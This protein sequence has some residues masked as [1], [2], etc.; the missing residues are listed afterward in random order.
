M[1]VIYFFWKRRKLLNRSADIWTV[2]RNKLLYEEIE[3]I[4]NKNVL[5]ENQPKNEEKKKR[6]KII[7]DFGAFLERDLHKGDSLQIWD[8]KY[9]PHDKEAILDAICLEIVRESDEKR[10]EVLK[11]GA[12]FLADFQK[13]IGDQPISA[14]GVDLTSQDVASLDTNSLK[15]LASRVTSNSD[16][17][18]FDL[19]KPII[20]KDLANIHAKLL[21]AQQLGRAMP[22]EKKRD[23]L[24]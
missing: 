8:V 3:R 10:I 17:K 12:L 18:Q 13:G 5:G 9:L 24:G 1:G 22:E 19:Y 7:S 2:R 11:V 16:S 20:D 23:I 6:L 4:K 14:L 21:A 15:E